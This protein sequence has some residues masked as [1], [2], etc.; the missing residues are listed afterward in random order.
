MVSFGL[1]LEECPYCKR[2]FGVQLVSQKILDSK[3]EV[4]G[5]QIPKPHWIGDTGSLVNNPANLGGLGGFPFVQDDRERTIRDY[6]VQK[7][8]KCKNCGNE[9]N[10]KYLHTEDD[11][12]KKIER[13]YFSSFEDRFLFFE[14]VLESKLPHSGETY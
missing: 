9:W 1:H 2:R 14:E 11:G 12:P 10:K 7:A 3:E 6:T 4:P 5:S 8:F 13:Q